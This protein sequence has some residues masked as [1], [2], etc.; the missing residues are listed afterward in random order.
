MCGKGICSRKR[1]G[2]GQHS[3]SFVPMDARAPAPARWSGPTVTPV[4][5]AHPTHGPWPSRAAS[6]HCGAA[7]GPALLGP[8]PHHNYQAGGGLG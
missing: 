4:T 7:L 5:G 1:G 2:A 3:L 6:T 8:R